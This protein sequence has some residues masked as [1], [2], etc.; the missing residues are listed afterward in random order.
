M[1]IICTWDVFVV[2]VVTG[3]WSLKIKW[4]T[5]NHSFQSALRTLCFLG[6]GAITHSSWVPNIL[7]VEERDKVHLSSYTGKLC[8]TEDFGISD[9]EMDHTFFS[10]AYLKSQRPL[11]KLNTFP[12]VSIEFC[13]LVRVCDSI[14]YTYDSWLSTH[15][16]RGVKLSNCC[17]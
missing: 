1:Q 17:K 16:A 9:T 3:P 2:C 6:V 13:F 11:L 15:L 14:N 4:N 12:F 7:V 10:D 5:T 8:K